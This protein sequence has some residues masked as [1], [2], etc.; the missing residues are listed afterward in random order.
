VVE[1]VL[2]CQTVASC[3]HTFGWMETRTATLLAD[4]DKS[5]SLALLR[6]LNELSRR[7]SRAGRGAVLSGRILAL[8]SS[9]FPLEERSGANMRGAFGPAWQPVHVDVPEVAAGDEKMQTDSV[10]YAEKKAQEKAGTTN[11]SLRLASILNLIPEFYNTFWSLQTPFAGPFVFAQANYF[12]KFRDS[13]EKVLPVIKEASAKDRAMMGSKAGASAAVL[14]RKRGADE[15]SP[16][17][18]YFFAK[19][20][21]SPDLLELE[22]YLLIAVV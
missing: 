16:S 4:M 7:T 12:E 21:T 11:P 9:T 18:D 5:R 6:M 14:K 22:V 8:L 20:L 17:E 19:F 3:A 10:D 13:V 15:A 2:E 1:D